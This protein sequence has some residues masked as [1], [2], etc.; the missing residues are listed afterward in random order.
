M[1]KTEQHSLLETGDNSW[2]PF[3]PTDEGDRSHTAGVLGELETLLGLR[4]G[5]GEGT[6]G[7]TKTEGTRSE[8]RLKVRIRF[9]CICATV[10]KGTIAQCV[11]LC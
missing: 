2:C 10:I 1:E 11:M 8:I 3:R 4:R 6:C 7:K 5:R 9:K